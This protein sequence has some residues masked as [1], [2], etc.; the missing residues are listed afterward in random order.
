LGFVPGVAGAALGNPGLGYAFPS[1]MVRPGGWSAQDWRGSCSRLEN[2]SSSPHHQAICVPASHTSGCVAH[3]FNSIDRSQSLFVA[4]TK[5]WPDVR[6]NVVQTDKLRTLFPF[7]DG[8]T[9]RRRRSHHPKRQVHARLC[10]TSRCRVRKTTGDE[11][12]T[13]EVRASHRFLPSHHGDSGSGK[14]PAVSSGLIGRG[15]GSG[16][17]M[18]GG[19]GTNFDGM[20]AV[21]LSSE[22]PTIVRPTAARTKNDQAR[23]KLIDSVLLKESLS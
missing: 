1:G 17:G 18:P 6:W 22:Q 19:R 21:P 11:S 5:H 20:I 2:S 16:F 4:V 12:R 7:D 8:P 3:D 10:S 13:T 23:S 14:I 9:R 15:P